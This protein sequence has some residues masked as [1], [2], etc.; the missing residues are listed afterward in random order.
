MS[1]ESSIIQINCLELVTINKTIDSNVGSFVVAK[2]ANM[3][4]Y[5]IVMK[6]IIPQNSYSYIK[7]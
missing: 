5:M 2:G 7:V 1:G 4:G 6:S 3:T